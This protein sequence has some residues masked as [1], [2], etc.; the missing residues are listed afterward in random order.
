MNILR[1]SSHAVSLFLAGMLSLMSFTAHAFNQFSFCDGTGSTSIQMQ[2]ITFKSGSLPGPGQ[3]LYETPAYN[4]GYTC[5]TESVPSGITRTFRPLIIRL[6]DI[7]PLINSLN[8]AGLGMNIIMQES[9]QPAVTWTWDEI[10]S[11]SFANKA[12]G[13]TIPAET[14]NVRR[15]ATLRMQFIV[16]SKIDRTQIVH[17]P[18]VSAFAISVVTSRWSRVVQLTTSGFDIRYIPD[19]YGTVSVMPSSFNLGHF[20]TFRNDTKSVSFSVTAAQ[21]TGTAGPLGT[22]TIPLNITF[23]ANGKTP[24]DAGQAVLLTRDDGQPNGLKLSIKDNDTAGNI[25]FGQ[26]STLGALVVT[27]TGMPPVPVVK[28]YTAQVGPAVTGQTLKTG[29]FSADVV[30]TV[31]YN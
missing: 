3:V 10:R 20:Y 14:N 29:N 21:R 9:G 27:G 16:A 28:R 15:A 25:T 5:T 31:T 12:F 22:F 11:G 13:A 4:I 8:D 30:A 26:A 6:G 23:T 7:Q 18:S 24:T 19:N 2:N 1:L 17:V